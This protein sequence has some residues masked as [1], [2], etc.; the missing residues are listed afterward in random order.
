MV[1]VRVEPVRKTGEKEERVWLT[2]RVAGCF[3]AR[4]QKV[5]LLFLCC[6]DHFPI[7]GWMLELA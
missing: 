5:W 1:V 6:V 7:P 2:R 4:Y 3:C